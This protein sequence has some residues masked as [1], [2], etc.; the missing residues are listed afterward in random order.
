MSQ[1]RENFAFKSYKRKHFPAASYQPCSNVVSLRLSFGVPL[2]LFWLSYKALKWIR[3]AFEEGAK[4][5]RRYILLRNICPLAHE[6][7]LVALR[8]CVR[9]ATNIGYKIK[10]DICLIKFLTFSSSPLKI[11]LLYV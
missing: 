3:S 7:G 8:T 2:F 6:T 11:Q 1:E 10:Q 5:M 4:V 9:K